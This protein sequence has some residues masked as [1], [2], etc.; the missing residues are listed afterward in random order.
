MPP[1]SNRMWSPDAV[2]S[3]RLKILGLCKGVR[4]DG[5]GRSGG[6]SSK[7]RHQP[8]EL[9]VKEKVDATLGP[10]AAS[11]CDGRSR[12]VEYYRTERSTLEATL[13]L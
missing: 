6:D 11:E 3:G 7:G 2:R 9:L 8:S 4:N 13:A 12:S 5:R 10:T 1:E